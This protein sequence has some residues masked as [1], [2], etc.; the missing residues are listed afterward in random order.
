MFRKS[1]VGAA[2]MLA[3]GLVAAGCSDDGDTIVLG[4]TGVV[5]QVGPE[6]PRVG[7]ASM[8][9]DI[10]T[11]DVTFNGQPTGLT[12]SSPAGSAT[13]TSG[14]SGD[15]TVPV[16]AKNSM[17]RLLF[18]LKAIVTKT[19]TG[20][21]SGDGNW[22]GDQY[23]YYGPNA[24]DLAS[25]ANGTLTITGVRGEGYADASL[26]N[27]PGGGASPSLTSGTYEFDATVDGTLQHVQVVL[28]NTDTYSGIATKIDAAM[29]G[30][31]VT[32]VSGGFR[33]TSDSYGSS[34]TV[35]LSNGSTGSLLFSEITS[36]VTGG[37]VTLSSTAP[38]N[39]V[40]ITV[41]WRD[42]PMFTTTDEY[43]G[44]LM[45]VGDA[46]GTGEETTV[47][48]DPFG[49]GDG[50]GDGQFTYG[51]SSPDG[52]YFYYGMRNNCT[53][54][55]LDTTTM[56]PTATLDVTGQGSL[57]FSGSSSEAFVRSVQ[58]SPDGTYLYAVMTT[59]IHQYEGAYGST[60]PGTD[61]DTEIAIVRINRATMTIVD[62]LT[63]ADNVGECMGS[64]MTLSLDGS[65]GVVPIRT[66]DDG[67]GLPADET[68]GMVFVV[69]LN[70]MKKIDGG[71]P[72]GA[73]DVSRIGKV[74]QRA[75][76]SAAGDKVYVCWRDNEADT[77][78]YTVIDI[79]T[80]KLTTLVPPTQY[81]SE[82]H[83]CTDAT[84][85]P[86]GRMYFTYYYSPYVRIYDPATGHWVEHKFIS[87]SRGI[88]FSKDGTRYYV[89]N[90]NEVYQFSM[91]DDSLILNDADTS[92]LYS[93][94]TGGDQGHLFIVSPY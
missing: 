89:C 49:R 75:A 71:G 17:G 91:A 84:A 69:D 9:I 13:Y 3:A 87:E 58:I 14:P 92:L 82:W 28:A 22:N 73:F 59:N 80:G 77:D 36:Q 48:M 78:F 62:K 35:T 26:A 37:T 47:D 52:H 23:F 68:Q 93:P 44:G 76:I 72:N 74:I 4:S 31:T 2:A 1:G 32:F 39:P 12:L 7:S 57:D 24:L 94:T 6:T 56:T 43:D 67:Y 10:D 8:S 29:T 41:Q 50:S 51:V 19:N 86:D 53:V 46:G 20:T 88:A 30:A 66:Y 81:S 25:T 85:G 21:A 11:G 79:A 34:A 90:D 54:V 5:R 65:R 18:N 63:L 33:F 61:Q 83:Y 27:T 16:S 64:K 45:Y 40:E 70:S 55:R 38:V 60:D 15:L 42:D